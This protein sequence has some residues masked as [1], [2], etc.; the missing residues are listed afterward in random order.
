MREDH[1]AGQQR[2]HDSSAARSAAT[3]AP[4]RTARRA[5]AAAIGAV[6]AGAATAG[7]ACV[8]GRSSARP[9]LRR[10]QAGRAGR[11]GPRPSGYRSASARCA[12]PVW[13]AVGGIE[14]QPQ[15]VGA[16]ERPSVSTRPTS[17]A[18]T[19]APRIEPMPPITMTTKARISTLSP[20]PGSTERIGATIAPAKP[21]SMAPKPNTTHEQ[22]ADIDAERRDHRRVAWRRRAPACRAGC[23]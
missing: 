16:K 7:A 23:G 18:A 15:Q 6:A 10:E 12:R 17:S 19:K 11:T 4:A 20:M 1:D 2:Q 3:A 5:A 14:Q 13:L 21:A 22:P 9:M 8:D